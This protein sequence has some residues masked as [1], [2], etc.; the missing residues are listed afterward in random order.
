MVID[1]LSEALFPNDG[2]GNTSPPTLSPEVGA[3]G[4]LI[5]AAHRDG[6]F[7]E[8]EQDLVTA[9]LMKLFRLT[10]PKAK[11]LREEAA[12][13]QAASTTSMTFAAAAKGLPADLREGLV[14]QM[15]TV[16]DSDDDL[17]GMEREV[18]GTVQTMFGLSRER[19]LALRPSA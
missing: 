12:S 14:T 4:L 11:A 19:L 15:W 5:E 1:K 13:A 18:M 9:A 7:T 17:S 3:A 8:V 10:N 2:D 6:A 16:A